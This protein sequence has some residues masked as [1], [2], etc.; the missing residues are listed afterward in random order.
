MEKYV[1][2]VIGKDY[3]KW[4]LNQLIFI[5]GPTGSGK[6]TF[7]L[8]ELVKFAALKGRK[9]LY[10]VNR[11][12]L[13]K[14]LDE[15]IKEIKIELLERNNEE[16]NKNLDVAIEVKMYQTIENECRKTPEKLENENSE[17]KYIIA[18]ECHYFL[19]DSTFNTNTQLSYDWIMKKRKQAVIIFIS[20]T[21]KRIKDYVLGEKDVAIKKCE[22]KKVSILRGDMEEAMGYVSEVL[23]PYHIEGDYTYVKPYILGDTA[24]IVKTIKA[25]KGKWLIFVDSIKRGEEITDFLVK[26]EIETIFIDALLKENDYSVRRTIEEISKVEKF[27]EQ[28][29]VATSVMDNGISI[30]DIKVRNLIIMS[31]T[32]EEFMQML[33]RKRKMNDTDDLDLYILQRDE[34]EFKNRLRYIEKR[35]KF[36]SEHG[37][38]GF[39]VSLEEL[40]ESENTYFCAQ[41]LC[42]VKKGFLKLNPF[43]FEQCRYLQRYYNHL[44]KRFREEGSSAFVR[45]QLEW[46]GKDKKY[47][48]EV[49]RSQEEKLKKS[50]CEELDKCINK[51]MSKEENL[52]LRESIR[53]HIKSLLEK[54]LEDDSIDEMLKE[55]IKVN[56]KEFGKSSKSNDNDPKNERPLTSE[57]FNIIVKILDLK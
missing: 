51:K 57:R 34:N 5:E 37:L 10:L 19:M 31:D 9:I 2:D 43:A 18:D 50:I 13:K 24:Q 55:E 42:Y 32:Q 1:S 4:K 29:L 36:I 33:G 44:I 14:Q 56:I 28:V 35:L 30:K 48:D 25:K 6:T 45:E 53:D 21:D 39:S 47:I 38:E 40:M 11:T 49:V 8:K 23:P 52:E 41:N 16:F 27:S 12:I 15:K 17:Y 20:A 7:V 26:T 46:L 22:N 3:E 54:R